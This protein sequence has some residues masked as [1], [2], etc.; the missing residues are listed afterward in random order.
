MFIVFSNFC[1]FFVKRGF[2]E[3]LH[4]AILQ[5]SLPTSVLVK[6]IVENASW[7]VGCSVC[8]CECVRMCVNTVQTHCYC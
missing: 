5:K 2:S 6:L 8:M 7:H 1:F 3:T 4:S